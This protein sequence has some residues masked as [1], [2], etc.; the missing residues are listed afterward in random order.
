VNGIGPT[1]EGGI[2]ESNG[3]TEP[4]AFFTSGV[5]LHRGETISYF[6]E[7]IPLGGGGTIVATVVTSPSASGS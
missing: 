6:Q 2:R 3:A 7:T 1:F 4:V 5:T